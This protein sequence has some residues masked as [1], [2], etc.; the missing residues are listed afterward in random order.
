MAINL[1]HKRSWTEAFDFLRQPGSFC[2]FGENQTMWLVVYLR[3]EQIFLKKILRQNW[4]FYLEGQSHLL[5][6]IEDL[7]EFYI[8]HPEMLSEGLRHWIELKK[9]VYV[10][11]P[12]LFVLA[13]RVVKKNQ[14]RYV[15]KF[16]KVPL[17]VQDQMRWQSPYF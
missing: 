15:L 2:L 1:L 8:E 13:S 16:P 5:R 10:S 17:Y 11:I 14:T 3:K 4:R 7:L 9:L 12:S 6:T